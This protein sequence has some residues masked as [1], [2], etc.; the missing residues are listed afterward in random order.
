MDGVTGGYR[1]GEATWAPHAAWS[2][3]TDRPIPPR[4]TSEVA[5]MISCDSREQVDA[6]NRAAA[7]HGGPDDIDPIQDHGSMHG[8]DFTSPHG[9]LQGAMWIDPSAIAGCRRRS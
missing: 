7:D 1:Q 6:M 5:L 4:G 2:E 8:R 3:F 9:Y